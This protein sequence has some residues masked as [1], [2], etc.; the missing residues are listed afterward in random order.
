MAKRKDDE[1]PFLVIGSAIFTIAL[2]FVDIRYSDWN[3]MFHTSGIAAIL[4]PI[5]VILHLAILSGWV[6]VIAKWKDPNYDYLRRI[7]IY[8]I[9]V[10]L[11]IVAGF[12]VAKNDNKMFQ[13]DVD[14]AKQ[15]QLQ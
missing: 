9:L 13:D 4:G 7:L 5:A 10:T 8:V 12:R 6:F 3:T 2:I 15:E 14:K 11:F 1:L